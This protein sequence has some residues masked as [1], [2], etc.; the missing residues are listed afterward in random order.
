MRV[1]LHT[2]APQGNVVAAMVHP[3]TATA[4]FFRQERRAL[5]SSARPL[6][7]SWLILLHSVAIAAA[8]MNVRAVKGKLM[9]S[10]PTSVGKPP[11]HLLSKPP[12][13]EYGG[14][15]MLL[16]CCMASINQSSIII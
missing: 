1:A 2:H 8:A 11:L 13:S 6:A 7:V 10:M 5:T 16:C 9:A 14:Y 15:V 4:A 12:R 3:S